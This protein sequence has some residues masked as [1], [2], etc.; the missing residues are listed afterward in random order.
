MA[1]MHAA[2]AAAQLQLRVA[3]KR[4]NWVSGISY[5]LGSLA[6]VNRFNR[7][8]QRAKRRV[9][10]WP[11]VMLSGLLKVAVETGLKLVFVLDSIFGLV[12]G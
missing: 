10:F 1:Q 4:V 5:C 3:E 12:E 7:N 6:R 2:H 9:D 11:Y 8:C